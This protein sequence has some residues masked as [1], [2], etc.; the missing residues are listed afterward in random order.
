VWPALGVRLVPA[1]PLVSA[2]R[3]APGVRLVSAVRP[4]PGVRL[5]SAAWTA[6]EVAAPR[7]ACSERGQRWESTG[8]SAEVG[9]DRYRWTNDH[10]S[11]CI[12]RAK[13]RGR[14]PRPTRSTDLHSVP[15]ASTLPAVDEGPL[16]EVDITI[17]YTAANGRLSGA[18]P[19]AHELDRESVSPGHAA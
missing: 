5:V 14:L 13:E 11:E 12:R 10:R 3:P 4:A 9:T 17:Y 15:I 8:R 19:K 16:P 2:V 18:A 6:R 1:V 7:L